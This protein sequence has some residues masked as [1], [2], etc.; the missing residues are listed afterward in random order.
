MSLHSL[1]ICIHEEDILFHI[2]NGL[3]GI[4]SR[5]EE[6]KMEIDLRGP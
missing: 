3:A 6:I 2:N 5:D 1:L 4:W